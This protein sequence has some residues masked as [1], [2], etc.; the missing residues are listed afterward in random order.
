MTTAGRQPRSYL[1][2]FGPDG[3]ADGWVDVPDAPTPIVQSARADAAAAGPEL[4]APIPTGWPKIPPAWRGHVWPYRVA[5]RDKDG[6]PADRLVRSQFPPA[7]MGNPAVPVDAFYDFRAY[8]T[9]HLPQEFPSWFC[10]SCG[11]W[12]EKPSFEAGRTRCRWCVEGR[13]S[14]AG[15]G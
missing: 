9:D 8:S 11:R 12:L 6:N 4:D 1:D 2:L 3:D 7:S 14:R 5:G 15:R 13:P 10:S